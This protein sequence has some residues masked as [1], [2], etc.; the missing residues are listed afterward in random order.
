[1]TRTQLERLAK[2]FPN[3]YIREKPGP[4]SRPYVSQDVVT[5]KLLVVLGGYD[6]EIG[7]VFKGDFTYYD[8]DK[9]AEV[10]LV[11]VVQGCLVT[12]HATIDGREVSVTEVGDVENPSNW[13]TE[14]AR[15]KDAISDGVKRCAMRL[16]CGLHLWSGEDFFLYDQLTMQHEE[17]RPPIWETDGKTFWQQ[18]PPS[19]LTIPAGPLTVRT[20]QDDS[21][22]PHSVSTSETADPGPDLGSSLGPDGG[23][24]K[25]DATQTVALDL[26]PAAAGDEP[27]VT[28][29]AI[30]AIKVHD[31]QTRISALQAL[32]VTVSA[33]RKAAGLSLLKPGIS[34]SE[35]AEWEALVSSLERDQQTQ[36]ARLER[37]EG[38]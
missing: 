22:S 2:P 10:V 20:K 3:R 4:G 1:M 27:P 18:P 32:K 6:L 29:I 15:M 24:R 21:A 16:G 7:E 33:A 8:K 38:K 13:R 9:K 37:K 31:L 14:G 11:D 35:F 34:V 5:Q 36:Q 28:D 17:E 26:P 30:S 12:I 19:T 23:G 25:N